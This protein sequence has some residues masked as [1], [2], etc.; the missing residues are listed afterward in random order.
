[1]EVTP[2]Q[3]IIEPATNRSAPQSQ[4]VQALANLDPV[5]DDAAVRQAIANA[6]ATNMDPQSLTLS[7]LAQA[8]VANPA[9]QAPPSVE[10]PQKFLKPDGAVDVDKI[11]ASTRQL[12]EA[13]QQKETAVAKT[14]EDYMR[15][16]SERETKFRNMPNP[17]KLAAN[18][19]QSIP[20]PVQPVPQGNLN[21]QQLE[22]IVRRDYQQDPLTTTA[23]LIDLAIQRRF[24]PIEE[25]E[26]VE[27]VRSN[28]QGL[29]EK[30]SRVLRPDV[31]AAINAKIA[32][33]P[34][35]ASRKNPHK[36]AWLEVKEELRLGDA[37]QGAQA[38]PSRPLSPVLGGGT[39]PSAPSASV[40]SSI[41]VAGSLNSLDLRDKKQEALG[42]E[43]VRR[44]LAGD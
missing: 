28:I 43:S 10:V 18:L 12:D 38:L 34:D 24:Q 22:E 2:G 32:S 1:M 26:K 42:D 36:A 5:L 23:R 15:E 25:K 9:F 6:E 7:D 44:M 13:I 29:A 30:D 8:P 35:I 14:V 16:Y 19:P 17:E 37:P 11:A 40:Q 4:P 31:F 39:P 27:S 33:D 41:N 3:V 21:E 20:Q